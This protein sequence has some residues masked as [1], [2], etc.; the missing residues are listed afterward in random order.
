MLGI[1]ISDQCLVAQAAS[2]VVCEMPDLLAYYPDALIINVFEAAPFAEAVEKRQ[3]EGASNA[4]RH[5]A[6]F[7]PFLRLKSP[8]R[9]HSQNQ[10]MRF[11]FDFFIH[12]CS[13]NG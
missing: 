9:N 13:S 5:K 6:N 7:T 4:L 8:L 1:D 10:F 11:V 2:V 3:D 12:F